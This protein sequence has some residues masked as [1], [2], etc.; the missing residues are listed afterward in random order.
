MARTRLVRG[1]LYY[2]WNY[3]RFLRREIYSGQPI[4]STFMN[5]LATPTRNLVSSIYRANSRCPSPVR[6]IPSVEKNVSS[7]H[8]ASKSVTFVPRMN[9]LVTRDYENSRGKMSYAWKVFKVLR[10]I[11]RILFRIRCSTLRP[12]FLPTYYALIRLMCFYVV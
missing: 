11:I 3:D 5:E 2:F 8:R 12:K 9:A 7:K 6:N 10:R 4:F 1:T